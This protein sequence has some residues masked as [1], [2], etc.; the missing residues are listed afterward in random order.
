MAGRFPGASDLDRFWDNLANGV[1]GLRRLTEEELRTFEPDY[2]D[3]VRDPDFVP[4]AGTLDDVEMFDA[5]FFGIQPGEART[6]D[7]AAPDL[8]R[9]RVGGTRERR[10]RAG[11]DGPC[12]SASSQAAT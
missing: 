2:Q 12:A 5:E 3:K 6:L 1:E 8:V 4:I 10:L 7:P 9:D 11:Q